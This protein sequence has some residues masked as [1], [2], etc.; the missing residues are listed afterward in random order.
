M[1]WKGNDL[2]IE[3]S[4][5]DAFAQ[6]QRKPS[7]IKVSMAGKWLSKPVD[8]IVN[9]YDWTFTTLYSGA[10]DLTLGT[11]NPKHR[12][13]E[14]SNRID[15]DLLRKRE[16]I[17]YYNHLVLYEDELSDNGSFLFI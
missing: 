13:S 3:F 14:T 16:D 1:L 15:V 8:K 12:W 9:S 7:E 2:V 11:L 17:L 5:L 4:A 6:V 10:I